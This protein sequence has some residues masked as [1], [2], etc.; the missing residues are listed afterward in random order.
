V[1]AII[2]RDEARGSEFPNMQ[3]VKGTLRSETSY[4][5]VRKIPAEHLTNPEERTIEKVPYEKEQ[6]CTIPISSLLSDPTSQSK[7][8]GV[9]TEESDPQ[10]SHT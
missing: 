4:Q 9:R 5:G 8:L 2:F 6:K 10:T 7:R 3:E 1:K